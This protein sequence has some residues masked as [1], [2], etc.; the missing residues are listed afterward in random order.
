MACCAPQFD[1]VFELTHAL[2]CMGLMRINPRPRVVRALRT[3]GV[4]AMHAGPSYTDRSIDPHP[5]SL[6][7]Q[8]PLHTKKGFGHAATPLD[9][10]GQRFAGAAF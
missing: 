9:L 3:D 2:A 5:H 4:C 6:K 1:K 8:R 7:N 10:G